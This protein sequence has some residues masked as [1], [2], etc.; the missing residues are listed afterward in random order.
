[1]VDESEAD[2]AP[3]VE[4]MRRPGLRVSGWSGVGS[5]E[6]DDVGPSE[7]ADGNCD[8]DVGRLLLAGDGED[9]VG[10]VVLP[11]TGGDSFGRGDVDEALFEGVAAD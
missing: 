2:G 5:G 8:R 6:G 10:R 4:G 9:E 11:G 3:S 7:V 1:M